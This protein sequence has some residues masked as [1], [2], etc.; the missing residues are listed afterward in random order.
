MV[1]EDVFYN[2]ILKLK[3]QYLSH[4]GIPLDL[5]VE[6]GTATGQTSLWAAE[7]F[8]NVVTVE[9]MDDLYA[10]AVENLWS[11]PSV[12][13]LH[14]DSCVWVERIF[15]NIKEPA[16]WFLDAHNVNRTDGLMPPEETPIMKEIEQIIYSRS[17]VIVIDDLRLFGTE[18]GYPSVD[19][20]AELV[21]SRQYQL[22]VF[23]NEDLLVAI[24]TIPFE[25]RD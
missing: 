18:P 4:W 2:R 16:I 10:S 12:R 13:V 15:A 20:I 23:N 3:S 19:D 25:E 22:S 17:E 8:K 7:H 6:T 9:F 24:G 5:F 11:C 14:G 1:N 21:E